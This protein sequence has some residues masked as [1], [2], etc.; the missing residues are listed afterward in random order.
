MCFLEGESFKVARSFKK[1]YL[2]NEIVLFA[3]VI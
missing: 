3:G 1:F 2:E